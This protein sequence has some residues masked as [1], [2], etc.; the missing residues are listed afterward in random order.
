MHGN[1]LFIVEEII[2]STPTS[3]LNLIYDYAVLDRQLMN[4]LTEMVPYY[5]TTSCLRIP[6]R[7]QDV[8]RYRIDVKRGNDPSTIEPRFAAPVS[9]LKAYYPERMHERVLNATQ[10]CLKQ[11]SSFRLD[12]VRKADCG[13]ITPN[14]DSVHVHPDAC[15]LFGPVVCSPTHHVV[16]ADVGLYT[17]LYDMMLDPSKQD[18]FCCLVNYMHKQLLRSAATCALQVLL[19]L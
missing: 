11:Y 14:T 8:L 19:S 10:R 18:H 3:L 2:S 15:K 17:E 7:A 5:F 16:L 6:E 4:W 13:D 9:K 1:V 12:I